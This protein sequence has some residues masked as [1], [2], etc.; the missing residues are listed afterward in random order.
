MHRH[1]IISASHRPYGLN[2]Q[3]IEHYV[4][5]L[6]VAENAKCSNHLSRNSTALLFYTIIR[7]DRV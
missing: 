2:V 1:G 5:S 4:I 6:N 7:Y 3:A